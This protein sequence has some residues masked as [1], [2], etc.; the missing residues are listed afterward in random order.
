MQCFLKAVKMI[1]F[2]DEKKN[3]FFLFLLIDLNEAVLTSTHDLCFR[4]RI[5]K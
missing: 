5:V 3:S 1:C 2:S 4:A